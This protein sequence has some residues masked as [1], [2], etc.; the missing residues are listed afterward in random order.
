MKAG[1]QEPVT[2]KQ[3]AAIHS[4]A[5]SVSSS[6]STSATS[7]S[8]MS[9]SSSVSTESM[10]LPILPLVPWLLRFQAQVRLLTL[11]CQLL[12]RLQMQVMLPSRISIPVLRPRI[13]L[14]QLSTKPSSAI[15]NESSSIA[16]S[17]SVTLSEIT[18][19]TSSNTSDSKKSSLS[20]GVR[21][22][23][24]KCSTKH[25]LIRKAYLVPDATCYRGTSFPD[26]QVGALRMSPSL[27]ESE[28]VGFLFEL[29]K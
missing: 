12:L 21:T 11:I 22:R 4:S 7:E 28:I 6:S 23:A 16:A 15:G 17:F 19:D 10:Q 26:S 3:S 2:V 25:I 14:V 9:S 8:S 18:S 20:M 24:V 13:Q 29:T 27:V 1:S 5:A